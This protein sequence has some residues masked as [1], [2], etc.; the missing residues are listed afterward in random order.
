MH[1]Q[2][3]FDLRRIRRGSGGGCQKTTANTKS[4]RPRDHL[5]FTIVRKKGG[6]GG[7]GAEG[8]AENQLESLG[9]FAHGDGA[10]RSMIG[11]KKCRSLQETTISSRIKQQVL[12]L[13]QKKIAWT[14]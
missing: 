7:G 13:E 9:R 12:G 5:Y 3:R 11:V 8:G 6:R 14:E 10:R 1:H 4:T 2:N